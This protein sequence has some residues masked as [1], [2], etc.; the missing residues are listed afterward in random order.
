VVGE[1]VVAASITTERGSFGLRTGGQTFRQRHRPPPGHA[2]RHSP[3][4]QPACRLMS[5]FLDVTGRQNRCECPTA[6]QGR[7]AALDCRPGCAC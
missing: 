5:G 7:P 4:L 1:G 6:A 3:R 2:R